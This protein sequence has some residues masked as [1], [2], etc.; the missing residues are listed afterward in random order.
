MFISTERRNAPE[1]IFTSEP[2][3]PQEDIISLLATGMTRA[4]LPGGR[5]RPRQPRGPAPREGAL[6]EGFQEGQRTAEDR[7]LFQS[8]ERRI[9]HGDTR[10]GEQTATAK[11][12]VTSI[13]SSSATSGCR[14]LFAG[15]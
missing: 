2:P 7:L 9:R 3:F 12:K 8:P 13:S 6:P 5:Q 4:E 11:Y 10:T 15:W 14:V 1:A